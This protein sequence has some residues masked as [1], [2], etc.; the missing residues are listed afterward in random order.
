MKV[1]IYCRVSTADQNLS[2]Q[3]RSCIQYA[4]SK[5][6]EVYRVYKDIISGAKDSRPEFNEML[7][8]MRLYR[9]RCIIVTKLDRIGRS[10]GHL[11]SLFDE[12]NSKK[13]WICDLR[14]NDYSNKP[15]RNVRPMQVL[16]RS[17]KYT[18]KT[19]YYSESHF[20]GYNKKGELLK[21]K[22]IVPFDTTGNRGYTGVPVN[23]FET[24]EAIG[25]AMG[26]ERVE[27]W[28][29]AG[30]VKRKRK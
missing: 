28:E 22:T 4:K 21:R 17:N 16:V 11:L 19:V 27:S 6:F 3:E 29:V 7:Q 1:A 26:R 15:I 5:N 10:L 25:R 12:F 2:N 20:V 23:C 14:Y 24:E 18:T 30:T 8:D 9:F 13:V